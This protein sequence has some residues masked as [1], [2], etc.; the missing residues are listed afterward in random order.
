MQYG[1]TQIFSSTQSIRSR[2]LPA[3]LKLSS[4]Y[5][6]QTT[7]KIKEI[8]VYLKEIESKPG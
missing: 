4:I 1:T 2:L 3:L 7:A 8:F 6:K 5:V